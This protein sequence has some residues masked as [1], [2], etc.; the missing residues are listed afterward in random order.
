MKTRTSIIYAALSVFVI[1]L[2]AS[3]WALDMDAM[4]KKGETVKVKPR[5]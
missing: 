4:K 3:A 5:T 1:G 2:T